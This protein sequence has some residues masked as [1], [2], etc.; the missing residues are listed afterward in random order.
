MGGSLGDLTSAIGKQHP[1]VR[2]F[3]DE[4]NVP[5]RNYP[6]LA[7]SPAIEFLLASAGAAIETPG[8][9]LIVFPARHADYRVEV[10]RLALR[11]A[12]ARNENVTILTRATTSVDYAVAQEGKLRGKYVLFHA[13]SLEELPDGSNIGGLGTVAVDV[14]G[15]SRETS[16]ST[17]RSRL[18]GAR[19]IVMS[20]TRT[21]SRVVDGASRQRE[22]NVVGLTEAQ[23]LAAENV[24]SEEADLLKGWD[25]LPAGTATLPRSFYDVDDKV[26]MKSVWRGSRHWRSA[27]YRGLATGIARRD[28][29]RST[30]VRRELIVVKDDVL[31]DALRV[32]AQHLGSAKAIVRQGG[33]ELSDTDH[34]LLGD[35]L[36]Y[37]YR[38]RAVAVPVKHYDKSASRHG[39]HS[40]FSAQL[41]DLSSRAKSAR[42]GPAFSEAVQAASAALTSATERLASVN[43]KTQALAGLLHGA[44]ETGDPMV[45]VVNDDVE[46]SALHAHFES[47]V[48]L[49]GAER[50]TKAK[51]AAR[52]VQ[53]LPSRSLRDLE[54]QGRL[55]LGNLPPYWLAREAYLRGARRVTA[56]VHSSERDRYSMIQAR[57][58]IVESYLFSAKRQEA[59]LRNLL[60]T[61]DARLPPDLV[62][63]TKLDEHAQRA[64]EIAK[65]VSTT[66]LPA[67]Y[68][69]E[70]FFAEEDAFA[71][72]MRRRAAALAAD[73]EET[74]LLDLPR[75]AQ[76][77]GVR[78]VFKDNT[79]FDC[80][81]SMTVDCVPEDER[82]Q[83]VKKA[84]RLREGD[85]VLIGS[86]NATDSTIVSIAG[87][88]QAKSTRAIQT[89]DDNN[90]W[91][92]AID[93]YRVENG[94]TWASLHEK[95][96]ANGYTNKTPWSL[97]SYAAPWVWLPD[98]PT[99][100]EAILKT[101][102][103]TELYRERNEIWNASWRLRRIS[104]RLKSMLKADYKQRA[105][106]KVSTIA[107]DAPLDEEWG[108]TLADFEDLLE[109][110]EVARVEQAVEFRVGDRGR[111]R[112]LTSALSS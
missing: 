81:P 72:A 95:C 111:V 35:L 90:R 73:K 23:L 101:V 57:E 45:I 14:D 84:E 12:S 55:V 33:D 110:K 99:N 107:P 64:L 106:G 29:L 98:D 36:D 74:P 43:P 18:L 52:G 24:P 1:A 69:N 13:R 105:A 9:H 96:K 22:T 8:W 49:G 2:S 88:L 21:E 67:V 32:A 17:L 46:Q 54:T 40:T 87:R 61:P 77:L 41:A 104:G 47:F 16:F 10:F 34:V 59:A 76:M 109:V 80:E 100:F 15:L 97:A 51:L 82:T 30:R 42:L 7:L 20:V 102:S 85:Y 65:T 63:E 92:V 4:L 5:A 31:E 94:H 89:V 71:R 60:G 28:L 26:W 44:Y 112:R 27:V 83:S 58:R 79:Y 91:R 39:G 62:P 50:A 25:W 19:S 56:V 75:S 38:L 11:A 48:K 37:F 103:P 108:V 6:A 3:L 78:V 70:E 53:I 66:P 68:D 86:E 93:A